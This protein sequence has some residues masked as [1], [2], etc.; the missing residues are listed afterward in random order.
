MYGISNVHGTS[1]ILLPDISPF[2]AFFK[3]NNIYAHI[4]TL[5]FYYFK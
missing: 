3:W 4:H 5:L 1:H 2:L